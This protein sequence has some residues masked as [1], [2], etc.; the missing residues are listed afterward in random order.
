MWIKD[1]VMKARTGDEKA[2]NWLVEHFEPLFCDSVVRF[3][4]NDET[5]RNEAKKKLPEIIR[6]Y[7][8]QDNKSCGIF[9]F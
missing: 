8:P 6:K 7:V 5:L 9:F 3:N 1:Y 4:S 2:F